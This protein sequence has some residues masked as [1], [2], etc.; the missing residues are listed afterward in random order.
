MVESRT[1]AVALAGG[2]SRCWLLSL[3]PVLSLRLDSVSRPRYIEPDVRIS[4]IRLSG[5]LHLIAVADGGPSCTWRRQPRRKTG[6]YLAIVLCAASARILALARRQ[7]C[8][9]RDRP[10]CASRKKSSLSSPATCGSAVAHL[11]P[12]VH[13]ARHSCSRTFCL[14]RLT[15]FLD[16]LAPR[17]QWPS[18]RN[19]CGP[20]VYPRKSALGLGMN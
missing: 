12:G 7:S 17:Y 2:S 19:R 6:A 11:F 3:A 5:R 1:G 18:L 15:L 20:N 13:I 14:S 10:A 4:R 9:R 8:P 16:G